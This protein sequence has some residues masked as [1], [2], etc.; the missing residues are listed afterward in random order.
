MG[1]GPLYSRSYV[2][3]AVAVVVADVVAVVVGVAV[4]LLLYQ[5]V[6]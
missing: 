1:I 5:H 6:L 4:K 2:A 3:D